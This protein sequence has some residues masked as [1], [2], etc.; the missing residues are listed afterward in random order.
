[1]HWSRC[2]CSPTFFQNI[3]EMRKDQ[4]KAHGWLGQQGAKKAIFADGR[5]FGFGPFVIHFVF[6]KRGDLLND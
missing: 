4:R 5:G 1:M 3:K 6:D 2:D